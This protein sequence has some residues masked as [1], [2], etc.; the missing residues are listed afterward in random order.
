MDVIKDEIT[1]ILSVWRRDHLN[2]QIGSIMSQSKKPYQV[3]IYQNENHFNINIPEEI[4]KEHKISVIQSKDINFKFHARFAL[5]LLCDT[6]YVAI[7]DDDTIPGQRWLENCIKT[8]KKNNS[9]VLARGLTVRP[10]YEK[11]RDQNLFATGDGRPIETDTEVDLGGHCWFFKTEWCNYM[12]RDRPFSWNNGED[13]HFSAACKFYGGIRSFVPE[14]PANDM[15]LWGDLEQHLGADQ[16]ATWRKSDHSVL[17]G[18]TV[19]YWINKGWKPL[20]LEK[21]E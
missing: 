6:E 10:G 11:Q 15:S 16:H 21:G 3:W 1:V 4:K 14:M 9:I 8:S 7:F 5:P 17:R 19:K 20:I 2:R 12:W 13:I 18:D